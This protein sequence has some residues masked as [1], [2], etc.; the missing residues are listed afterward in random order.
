MRN[1]LIKRLL[2]GGFAI[3]GVITIVFG[4][5]FLAGDPTLLLVPEGATQEDIDL[6]RHQFGFD[7][8]FIVQYWDYLLGVL[9]FDL[10]Q[11]F[12]QNIPVVQIIGPRVPFTLYLA[13]ASLLV[14]VGV[15]LPVGVITAVARDTV[16]ERILMP[17]VLVGQSM[18]TFWSGILLILLFAVTLRILPSSGA[19]SLSSIIMP[20]ISLGALSMATFARITRTSVIDEMSK[21]YVRSAR[22]KGIAVRAVILR[23]VLRNA[24]LPVIT[25]AALEL[26]NLLAGAVIVETVFAWPGLGLL[27]VQ[28]IEARD[29]FVVQAIVLLG[30]IIYVVLNLAADIL[31]SAVDPRIKLHAGTA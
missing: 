6:L 17:I 18:P 20:A 8:P 23:H 4:I 31:Y 10:G 11:S 16:T 25:V 28:S 1:F 30:S 12:V 27:A 26:A 5:L 7:R 24:S 22:A 2:Q 3:W 13:G 29:F 14:A 9:R 19:E 15:G 21:D